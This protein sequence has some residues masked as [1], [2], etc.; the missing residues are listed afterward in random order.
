MQNWLSCGMAGPRKFASD[1]IVDKAADLFWRQDYAATTPVN[2]SM[3]SGS[4]SA[5]LLYHSFESKHNLF[6]L[7][8]R[9]YS[10]QRLQ[11]LADVSDGPGPVRPRLRPAVEN[12]AGIGEHHRGCFVVNSTA[13]RLQEDKTVAEV[14]ADLFRWIES[15]FCDAIRHGQLIGE[16]HTCRDPVDGCD[17]T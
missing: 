1:V 13:E 5:V 9:R 4:A 8:L 6:L 11:L 3:N 10:A 12:L 14:S 7:A 15:M 2:L 16:F 17:R